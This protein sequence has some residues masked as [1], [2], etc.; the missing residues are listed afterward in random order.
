MLKMPITHQSGLTSVVN[1]VLPENVELDAYLQT[2]RFYECEK[3]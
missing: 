1:I 2:A 3:I